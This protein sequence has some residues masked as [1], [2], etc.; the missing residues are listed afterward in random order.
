MRLD[1]PIHLRGRRARSETLLADAGP[2]AVCLST[3]LPDFAIAVHSTYLG[4]GHA[5]ETRVSHLLLVGGDAETE[6]RTVL[7]HELPIAFARRRCLYDHLYRVKELLDAERD[8]P[9]ALVGLEAAVAVVE[10]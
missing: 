6:A 8:G 2:Y 1:C 7:H 4:H 10:A 9:V 3:T 5:A